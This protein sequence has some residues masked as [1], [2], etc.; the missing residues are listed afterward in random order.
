MPRIFLSVLLAALTPALA[1]SGWAQSAQPPAVGVVTA[2]RK[3]ITETSE[4]VG[5]IQA[6][7]RV[8][9][10]ARVTAFLDERLFDEGA[11]V[12]KGDLL[13]RL[14]QAPFTADVQVK[15]AGVK[16]VE[17][18]LRNADLTLSRARQLL[19]TSAGTTAA[20][21][22]AEAS[23][24]S[25]SAQ[26]LAAQAA[27]R[28]SQINLDY[29][30]I[31]A[32]IDGKI[33]RSAT[34]PGNVV[35]PGSGVLATIVS[36]DPMFITFSVPVRSVLD[37]RRRFAQEG[38]FDAL[39]VRIRLPDGRLY[40]QTGKLDFLD[41]SVA[42]NTDTL[43]MRATIANPAVSQAREGAGRTRELFDGEFVTVLL[44]GAEP[45]E[46]LTVPRAAVLSDQAGDYVYVVD[47]QGKARQQRLKLG[48]STPTLA[49]VLSGLQE[50][51][52]VISEGLQ[53]VRPGQ[54]VSASP[55]VIPTELDK[56][57][58]MN[59]PANGNENRGSGGSAPKGRT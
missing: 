6:T 8:V 59:V 24:R 46:A 4:Y 48:Q 10:S 40:G 14:E 1:G 15:D 23:Q 33:G 20:V 56:N 39:K 41:N 11:E 51:Q 28:Q 50:G 55:V 17:A 26:L 2:A 53:R 21:D 31:K 38:G 47:A 49:V 42:G 58:Q 29:T 9:L 52:T 32:P 34:T 25:L 36:Q 43:A 30:E 12:K 57:K 18:Q 3:P 5:R 35:S 13:Y 7:D 37:L 16:Q 54:S 44:E 19:A 27:L 45:V 22:S